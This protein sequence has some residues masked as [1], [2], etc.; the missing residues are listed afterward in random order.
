M[1]CENNCLFID[2]LSFEFELQFGVKIHNLGTDFHIYCFY[3][4]LRELKIQTS[5]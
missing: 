5:F 1:T 3:E 4:L 2:K